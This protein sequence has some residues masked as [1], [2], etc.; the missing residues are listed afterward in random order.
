VA[1]DPRARVWRVETDRGRAEIR[2]QDR[3]DVVPLEDGRFL[4]HDVF[5]DVH[6]L[7]PLDALDRRS[8]RLALQMI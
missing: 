3:Q 4:I 8:R 7:P 6:L 1:I 5:G 2:M